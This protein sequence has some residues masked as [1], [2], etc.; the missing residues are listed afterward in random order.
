MPDSQP[1]KVALSSGGIPLSL[2]TPFLS[3][4]MAAVIGYGTAKQASGQ[5][6][7]ENQELRRLAVSNKAEIDYLRSTS[8][9]KDQMEL[10]LQMVKDIRSDQG[11]I[12]REVS[13]I[14]RGR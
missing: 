9:S 13:E 3:I 5:Y 2:L 4:A 14:R 12:K 8:A 1:Q 11:E 6:A 7:A 10:M